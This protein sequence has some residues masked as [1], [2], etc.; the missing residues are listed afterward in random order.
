MDF[1]WPENV[2]TLLTVEEPPIFAAERSLKVYT[3]PPIY[4]PVGSD[5]FG[6]TRRST[7]SGE[8]TSESPPRI[9]EG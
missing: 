7:S 1:L 9:S 8:T 6:G 4:H 2:I 5:P 3:V